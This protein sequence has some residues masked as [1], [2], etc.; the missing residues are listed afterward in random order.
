MTD[1]IQKL[2]ECGCG[3]PTNPAPHTS[4]KKGW[5]KGQPLRFRHGHHS[6]GKKQSAEHV[7][8]KVGHRRGLP[9]VI[10]GPETRA[11]M[12]AAHKG[13]Q[14]PAE[15][16]ERI[17]AAQRGPLSP[18]WKGS[19][20]A[21][22]TKHRWMLRN[23]TKTGSCELCGK[24]PPTPRGRQTG[25]LWANKNHRY[26]R[27][28]TRVREDWIELC[29][30]CHKGYDKARKNGATSDFLASIEVAKPEVPAAML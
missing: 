15:V 14:V 21:Y 18:T 13:Q 22:V 28:L 3:T 6:R 29:P 7:E 8:K 16:R 27:D 30:K 12:S 20:A 5:V 2:C 23:F 25:T 4:A 9:G 24:T 26:D 19:S 10:P 17:A 11:K 1:V